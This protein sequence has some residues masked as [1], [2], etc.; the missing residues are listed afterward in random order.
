VA[1]GPVEIGAVE[2][3]AG[4]IE[5]EA[6][7]SVAHGSTQEHVRLDFLMEIAFFERPLVKN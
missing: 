4:A 7:I 6:R 2:I 1:H 5:I 3:E